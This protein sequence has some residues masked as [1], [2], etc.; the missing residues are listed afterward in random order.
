MTAPKMTARRARLLLPAALGLNFG[1]ASLLN[2]D[3]A[4]AAQFPYGTT[5]TQPTKI[6][7]DSLGIAMTI[8]AKLRPFCLDSIL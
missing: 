1:M 6:S 2:A 5:I 4:L 3:Y 8:L 7:D